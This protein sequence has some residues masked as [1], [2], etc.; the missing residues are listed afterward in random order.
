MYLC[1]LIGL[2]GKTWKYWTHTLLIVFAS[3]NLTIYFG[4]LINMLLC[5]VKFE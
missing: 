4:D 1:G 3:I 2:M 5:L